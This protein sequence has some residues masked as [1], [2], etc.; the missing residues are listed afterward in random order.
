M[1]ARRIE[2]AGIPFQRA[3]ADQ[4]GV[5]PSAGNGKKP[6]GYASVFTDADCLCH[7]NP[8]Q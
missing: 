4:G 8:C 2:H 5:Y 3:G 7:R 1:E 6:E